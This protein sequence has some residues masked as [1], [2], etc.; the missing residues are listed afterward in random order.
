MDWPLSQSFSYF[1]MGTADASACGTVTV[2][3][4]NQKGS[5]VVL[6]PSL[7]Q[8]IGELWIF[9]RG[10]TVSPRMYLVD[11][12]VNL[13]GQD[14]VIV[15][16]LMYT[17]GGGHPGAYNY[18]LPITIPQGAALK[19]KAQG[20]TAG[21]SVRVGALARSIA[22]SSPGFT[23]VDSYGQQTGGVTRGL[24]VDPSGTANAVGSWFQITGSTTR[25]IKAILL[26][27]GEGDNAS[28]APNAMYLAQ[29]GIGPLGQEQVVIP[30]IEFK[31]VAASAIPYP[32][33]H[34]P[35]PLSIPAGSRVSIRLGTDTGGNVTI[36]STD[37][38]LYGLG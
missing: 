22:Q 9:G 28:S 26:A 30:A 5:T 35:F 2:V 19:L 38:I 31:M 13:D 11:V 1:S 24:Q 15:P 4:A 34:G 21:S 3:T 32:A 27:F 36:N 18:S 23:Y 12:V 8:D 14:Q 7:P 16:N 25:D 17:H 20:T 29:I 6:S 10:A 33:V 37:C